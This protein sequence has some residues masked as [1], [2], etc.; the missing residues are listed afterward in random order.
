[1]DIHCD[2][3]PGYATETYLCEDCIGLGNGLVSTRNKRLP[4]PV[5]IQIYVTTWHH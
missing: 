4:E 2:P 3:A 5:F 1:M